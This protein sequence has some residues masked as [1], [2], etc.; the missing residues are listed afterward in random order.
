MVNLWVARKSSNSKFLGLL[1]GKVG[2]VCIIVDLQD[3]NEA[4]IA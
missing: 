3:I 2:K 4:E 1:R